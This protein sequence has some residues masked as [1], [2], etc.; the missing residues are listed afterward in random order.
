[1]LTE[2]IDFTDHMVTI[3]TLTEDTK[4]MRLLGTGWEAIMVLLEELNNEINS[5][6]QKSKA[7]CDNELMSIPLAN[8]QEVKAALKALFTTVNFSLSNQAVK[9]MKP[10]PVPLVTIK[11]IE[12]I[13]YYIQVAFN[14]DNITKAITWT[15]KDEDFCENLNLTL[16]ESGEVMSYNSRVDS[17]IGIGF[18][19]GTI[20]FIIAK[21]PQ[22]RQ[23]WQ[24]LDN[25]LATT[26]LL[27]EDNTKIMIDSAGNVTSSG[28]QPQQ[29]E[30]KK[31]SEVISV[32]TEG[33]NFCIRING[34][35]YSHSTNSNKVVSISGRKTNIK[36]RRLEQ[37]ASIRNDEV[38]EEL[39]FYAKLK[40][41]DTEDIA[42]IKR[43]TILASSLSINYMHKDFF[44]T[45]IIE[46]KKT[47]K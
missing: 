44:R 2:L 40:I 37:D 19:V 4:G 29:D 14:D 23:S 43:L 46:M 13:T 45:L 9:K 25:I 41:Y 33:N 32:G 24:L 10:T 17:F 1:M 3:N 21:K 27:F 30:P 6:T 39:N 26:L 7:S 16:M 11:I 36:D 8:E 35:S 20:G 31:Q 28:I 34:G 15:A 22:L 42:K 47:L 38:I 18:L 12:A 5:L